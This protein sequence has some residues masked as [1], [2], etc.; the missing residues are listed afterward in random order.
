MD[1]TDVK[2]KVVL[3]SSNY[4]SITGERVL[5]V[6]PKPRTKRKIIVASGYKSMSYD[7]E[8][9][10]I[11]DVLTAKVLPFRF[12]IKLL[13]RKRGVMTVGMPFKTLLVRFY[14]EF[15]GKKHLDE[16]TFINN[17]SFK[18][19]PSDNPTGDVTEARNRTVFLEVAEL[20]NA[21]ID[22]FKVAKAKYQVTISQGHD[23]VQLLKDEDVTM[24]RAAFT[25]ERDLISKSRKDHYVKYNDLTKTI[26]WIIGIGLVIFIINKLV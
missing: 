14:I 12:A 26:K 20:A 13:L 16:S 23:P 18:L 22:L 8:G 15:S 6:K 2:R 21:V 17:V 5:R 7:G 11:G 3:V 24:A 25:V 1:N 9:H 19:K 10:T 4:N